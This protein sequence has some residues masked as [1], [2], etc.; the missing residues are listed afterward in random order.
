MAHEL[1]AAQIV[2][3][4]DRSRLAE[5]VFGS[6]TSNLVLAAPVA[7]TV[8]PRGAVPV[9]SCQEKKM[10][11]LL[12]ALG[13]LPPLVATVAHAQEAPPQPGGI[14]AA[15]DA[16]MAPAADFAAGIVFFAIPIAGVDVPLVVIWPATAVVFFTLYFRF[17]DFRPFGHAIE[18][19]RGDWTDPRSAGEVRI[20]RRW[21]RHSRVPWAW[22]TSPGSVS[23][24]PLAAR[25][26]RC[27]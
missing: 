3:R 14:D 10:R 21:R 17:I 24:A 4:R 2:G 11:R 5:A 26:R 19:I 18:L 8:V 7:V 6:I 16:F 1:G 15:I 13:C 27:G 25:G 20:S 12:V 22:A 23:P 9:V